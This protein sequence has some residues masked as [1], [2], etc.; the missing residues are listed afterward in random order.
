VRLAFLPETQRQRTN[1]G[2]SLPIIE[3]FNDEVHL[4][5]REYMQRPE[6]Q[7]R[8]VIVSTKY[9]LVDAGTKVYPYT[10]GMTYER[11]DAW[12]RAFEKQW[13]KSRERWFHDVDDVFVGMSGAH[14]YVLQRLHV[15]IDYAP[16]MARFVVGNVSPG[17]QMERWLSTELSD[18]F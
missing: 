12:H 15:M 10:A 17:A 1:G 9:G 14:L 7:L 3:L 6:T 4:L 2:G 18:S 13:A 5:A 8:V 16:L 11:V